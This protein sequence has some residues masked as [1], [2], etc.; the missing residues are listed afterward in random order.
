ML[1]HCCWNIISSLAGGCLR[2]DLLD[3]QRYELSCPE[4]R[5][6]D[7]LVCV[8]VC[9]CLGTYAY[10]NTHTHACVRACVRT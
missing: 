6:I 2:N 3:K 7:K 8:H 4:K 10:P 9:V 5:K 1:W